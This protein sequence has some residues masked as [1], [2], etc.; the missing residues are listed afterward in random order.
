MSVVYL[1]DDGKKVR[2]NICGTMRAGKP[3]DT[4]WIKKESLPYH[5]KSV[6]HAR[7]VIAQ[8]ESLSS[9]AARERSL[10]EEMVMEQEMDFV[11][12]TSS[13]GIK[14]KTTEPTRVLGNSE[15]E[16]N[17]WNNL[18]FSNESFNAGVDPNT[19]AAEERKQLEK[20]A[21]DFDIWHVENF[22]P[23]EDT[24]TGELLLDELEQDDILTE[25]LRNASK[26]IPFTSSYGLI[27]MAF[28]DRHKCTKCI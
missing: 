1:S 14:N 8:R 19:A 9:Q 4:T 17:M 24:T 15:E 20:E 25:L 10:R 13:G 2:C 6:L 18:L 26:F 12:L 23:E 3:E 7:A 27:H 5:L 11:N 22:L 28:S 16:E 21:N